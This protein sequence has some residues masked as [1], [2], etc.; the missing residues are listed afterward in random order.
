MDAVKDARMII[1]GRD[2]DEEGDN[3]EDGAGGV[4]GAGAGDAADLQP[5]IPGATAGKGTGR[6]V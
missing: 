2:F 5:G 3:A 6:Q 4:P 1:E